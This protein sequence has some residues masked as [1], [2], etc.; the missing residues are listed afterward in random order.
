MPDGLKQVIRSHLD[1]IHLSWLW[2]AQHY[3]THRDTLLITLNWIIVIVVVWVVDGSVSLWCLH[4]SIV[5]NAGFYSP[6]ESLSE[7][8][9]WLRQQRILNADTRV[10][11]R[12]IPS[13]SPSWPGSIRW[14]RDIG[15]VDHS[16]PRLAWAVCCRQAG[17]WF[18]CSRK[19]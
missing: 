19:L 7:P 8:E 6:A 2:L 4:T 1:L 14:S 5:H 17:I 15:A 3:A 18:L 16:W 9:W 12:I 10:W 13:P 11:L